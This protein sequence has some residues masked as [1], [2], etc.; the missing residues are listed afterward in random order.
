VDGSPPPRSPFPAIAEYG[1]LSDLETTALVAADGTVEWLCLPRS[2]G[3]SVFGALLDRSAGSFRVAP[4]G[5]IVPT[6]RRYLPGTNVLETTWQTKTGWLVV[7]D[8]LTIGPWY[9]RPR[10]ATRRTS[11]RRVTSRQSTCWSGSS[12]A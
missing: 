8:A 2:D 9:E 7:R 1:F 5:R 12:N 4:V 11:D 6:G 10:P 3:P